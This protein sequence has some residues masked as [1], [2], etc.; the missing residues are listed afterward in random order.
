MIDFSRLGVKVAYVV[1]AL[2]ALT[3]G[4][5]AYWG[6]A[7][8]DVLDI[9]QSP[10]PVRPKEVSGPDPTIIATIDY[11][12]KLDV[13]GTAV[14]TLVSKKTVL[15]TP[16]YKDKTPKTCATLEA[17]L[18]IPPQATPDVYHYHWRV[19]YKVNPIKTVVEEFDTEEFELKTQGGEGG[20][21]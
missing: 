10:V 11:C 2:A 6:A 17:A 18:L 7:Q 16:A 1:V 15:L 4:L 8:Y 21:K 9:R 14:V 13:E 19:V 3:T 12:K 5:M 20:I